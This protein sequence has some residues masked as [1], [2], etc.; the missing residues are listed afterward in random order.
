ME[1]KGEVGT[2]W[3]VVFNGGA[4]KT[5][6][7]SWS[8]AL[9]PASA[10]VPGLPAASSSSD[11]MSISFSRSDSTSSVSGSLSLSMRALGAASPSLALAG[12][13]T[14]STALSKSKSISRS[15]SESFSGNSILSLS[16]SNDDS[17]KWTLRL[18]CRSTDTRRASGSGD[19]RSV[20][21]GRSCRRVGEG[22]GG[23]TGATV[24]CGADGVG[25][26]DGDEVVPFMALM[27]DARG[28]EDG[29]GVGRARR[30]DDGDPN[31]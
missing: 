12:A 8:S 14:P 22:E 13:I 2:V 24:M 16:R 21:P 4:D 3:L 9:V 31:T 6:A 25:G 27:T 30:K 17:P 15:P 11:A 10:N 5:P 26:D 20:A 1:K 7:L 18:S 23:A 19:A 28:E 29:A